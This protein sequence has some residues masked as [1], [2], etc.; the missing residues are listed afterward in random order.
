M[1]L[2]WL[3]NISG[4]KDPDLVTKAFNGMASLMVDESSARDFIPILHC[5]ALGPTMVFGIP[6]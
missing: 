3:A 2:S 5:M 1:P 4:P 6:I